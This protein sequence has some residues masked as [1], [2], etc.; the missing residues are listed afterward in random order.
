M[1]YSRKNKSRK[2]KRGGFFFGNKPTV[3]PS[4]E[5]DP[6]NLVNIQGSNEL[7]ANYQKC[8]PKGFMGTKNSSPYCKQ[9]DLNFQA[10]LKSENNALGYAGMSLDQAQDF[11]MKT[12]DNPAFNPP[13][14]A[15]PW[16]KF[17]GGKS[18]KGKRKCKS[19]RESRKCKK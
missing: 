1:K 16:W 13:A 14:P 3:A 9:L 7:H 11:E 8:C 10:A 4:A 12:R 15:K 6:N 18:R 2:Q 5:C 17:W 19:K